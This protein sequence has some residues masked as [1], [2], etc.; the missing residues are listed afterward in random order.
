MLSKSLFIYD[1]ILQLF[2]V[3]NQYTYLFEDKFI[4]E[5]L[6]YTKI[7]LL[8]GNNFQIKLGSFLARIEPQRVSV[9]EQCILK[10]K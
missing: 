9:F 4:F 5:I 6:S 7:L 8:K 3:F 10:L 2:T 1:E